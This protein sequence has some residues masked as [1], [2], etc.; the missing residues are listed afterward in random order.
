MAHRAKAAHMGSCLS[1]ADILAVLYS[2]VLRVRPEYPNWP[3]RDRLILSKGHA[4]MAL[5]ATLAECGFFPV[6]ELQEYGEADSRLCGHVHADVPG[7]EIST[8]SLGHGLSIGCGMALAAKANGER[9]RVFVVL[10]DGDCQSGAT[11]EAAMF[12]CHHELGNLTA[13]IDRNRLQA[14]GR[15][16][17][18][19]CLQPL[20]MKWAAFGWETEVVDGHD[21]AAL[22]DAMRH[23]HRGRPR[24]II[25]ETTKG[26]GCPPIENAVAGHYWHPND[27]EL[28]E[29]MRVLEEI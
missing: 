6:R 27:E 14:C 9:S 8:G 19:M 4:A 15:T 12:A 7:I 13:I 25:A 21:H 16:E 11:W 26:K 3:D 10:S 20:A 23:Q 24:V 5:Y 18:V 29:A 28:A 17:D 2:G 1:V 22:R